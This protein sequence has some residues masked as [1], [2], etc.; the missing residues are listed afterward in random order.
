ME[1]RL[2]LPEYL[3]SSRIK[4]FLNECLPHLE[5]PSIKRIVLDGTDSELVDLEGYVLFIILF[6][7]ARERGIELKVLFVPDSHVARFANYILGR[8]I[9]DMDQ[10]LEEKVRVKFT[11]CFSSDET[12]AATNRLANLIK[13]QMKPNEEVANA[14]SWSIGELTDNAGIHGYQAYAGERFPKAVY[15]TAIDLTDTIHLVI[16]D[17][18]Q[19]IINSLRSKPEFADFSKNDL[20]AH[21]LVE[22]VSG[23]P[24]FSPGFGLYSCSEIIKRSNGKMNIFTNGAHLLI[25]NGQVSVRSILDFGGTLISVEINKSASVPLTEIIGENSTG[26]L[27]FYWEN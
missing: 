10:Y 2:T 22:G 12:N 6:D 1:I 4:D 18:G 11:R 9:Y 13:N 7:I 19:G 8:G 23:H 27:E 21:A 16:A 17:R 5:N 25:E 26:M 15:V 24:V 3:A 20:L 14:L